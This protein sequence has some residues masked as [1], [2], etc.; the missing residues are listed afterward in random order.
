MIAPMSAARERS[1]PVQHHPQ[2]VLRV[3]FLILR[4]DVSLRSQCAPQVPTSA[5]VNPIRAHLSRSTSIFISG[6]PSSH[7]V[8][9]SAVPFVRRHDLGNRFGVLHHLFKIGPDDLDLERGF[10]RRAPHADRAEAGLQ[11]GD[12]GRLRP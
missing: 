5:S 4:R 3:P 8:V 11:S 12:R 1:S 6:F 2:I 10:V 9:T 7:E